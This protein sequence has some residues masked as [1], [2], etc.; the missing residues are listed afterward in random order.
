MKTRDRLSDSGTSDLQSKKKKKKKLDNADP[1]KLTATER[2]S[3][4][5]QKKKKK[6]IAASE[7]APGSIHF[8]VDDIDDDED[9]LD[10]L[11]T[12]KSVLSGS[13]SKL[14]HTGTDKD[15]VKGSAHAR[16]QQDNTGSNASAIATPKSAQVSTTTASHAKN[17]KAASATTTQAMIHG[18]PSLPLQAKSS[19]GMQS[20]LSVPASVSSVLA[21]FQR[22][23]A[24]SPA[25]TSVQTPQQSAQ[26]SAVVSVPVPAQSPSAGTIAPSQV[27][28]S[29]PAGTG[30]GAVAAA[31]AAK[32]YANL[33][34]EERVAKLAADG[35][36]NE[37]IAMRSGLSLKLVMDLR[38]KSVTKTLIGDPR[39][40]FAERLGDFD[41]AFQVART[42]YHD[43]PG[44]ETNY[45]VMAEFAKTMRELVK[46][47]NELED[48]RDIAMAIANTALRPLM[49]KLLK[50]VVDN[51]NS[52]LKSV[53]PYLK[54][55]ERTLL[56]DNLR[57]GMKS[58]QD[59]VNNDYNNAVVG[60][61][62]IFGVDLA[63]V[64][65]ANTKPP[66]IGDPD[67]SPT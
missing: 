52:A 58:M 32:S 10:D 28:S 55:Q 60:L 4:S 21:Q 22:T 34:P 25:P 33:P 43:D 39:K 40:L 18:S 48:P 24:P 46:D 65:V 3:L 38:K 15:K 59:S 30:A 54:D 35:L 47:Y 50:T 13:S 1:T 56:G 20:P 31:M 37:Q 36:T 27:T 53:A 45:R 9:G 5:K 44:S 61:E 14:A 17:N 66:V 67:N 11:I 64:K 2:V 41:H 19:L 63:E 29:V 51:V 42:M 26:P 57:V 8:P 16:T 49:M 62:Q 7:T 6:K 12:H 23:H